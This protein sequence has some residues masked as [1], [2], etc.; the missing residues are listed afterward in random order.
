MADNVLLQARLNYWTFIF[1]TIYHSSSLY[2]GVSHSES[3]TAVVARILPPMNDAKLFRMTSMSFWTTC[4]FRY[5]N[6]RYS[7]G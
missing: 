5:A 1:A 2:V 6:R 4:R 3:V 7:Q